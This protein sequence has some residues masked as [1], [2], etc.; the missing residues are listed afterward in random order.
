MCDG[1]HNVERRGK[2]ENLAV[3]DQDRAVYVVKRAVRVDPTATTAKQNIM[4]TGY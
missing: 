4:R 2:D 1:R 3:I